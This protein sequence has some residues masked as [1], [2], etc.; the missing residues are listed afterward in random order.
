MTKFGG[1]AVI[2]PDND[3]EFKYVF[4]I[5]KN[6]IQYQMVSF[7]WLFFF[8]FFENGATMNIAEESVTECISH[9][10]W[11]YSFDFTL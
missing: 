6:H 10:L 1:K 2:L 5:S 8:S 7:H 11:V 3:S 4:F 9:A